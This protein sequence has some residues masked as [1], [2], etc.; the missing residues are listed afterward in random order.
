LAAPAKVIL[1]K[2]GGSG[3]FFPRNWAI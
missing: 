2:T 3:A 1:D